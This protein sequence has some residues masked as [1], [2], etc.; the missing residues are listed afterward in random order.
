MKITHIG[1]ETASPA[2]DILEG[3]APSKAAIHGLTGYSAH[4]D[5]QTL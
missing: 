2:S 4:A 3:R 5:Q 1:T